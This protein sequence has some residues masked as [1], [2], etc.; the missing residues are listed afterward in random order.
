MATSSVLKVQLFGHPFMKRLRKFIRNDPNQRYDFQLNGHLIIQFSGISGD[1]V[2]VLRQ[3]HSEINV[4]FQPRYHH[5][6]YWNK[7]H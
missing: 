5:I 1:T 4:R 2:A 6:G 7:R 3:H